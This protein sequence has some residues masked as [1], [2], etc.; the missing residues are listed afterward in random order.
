MTE[1]CPP[2]GTKVEDRHPPPLLDDADLEGNIDFVRHIS[3]TPACRQATPKLV[4]CSAPFPTCADAPDAPRLE[5]DEFQRR[6]TALIKE[7]FLSRDLEG[8]M[9]SIQALGCPSY[10]DELA[11]LLLR[12]ALD[13][14][15]EERQSVV[16]LMD[17]LMNQGHLQKPQMMR[18]FEKLVLAWDD[19][20]LDVPD[21]AGRIVALLSSKV[22]LLDKGLFS[23]LP[24]DLLR[25]LASALPAGQPREVLEQHVEDLAEFKEQAN[26]KLETELFEKKDTNGIAT[27]LRNVGKPCFHHE[28]VMSACMGALCTPRELLKERQGLALRLLEDLSGGDAVLDEVDLHLGFSRLL[29]KIGHLTEGMAAAD[30][31]ELMVGLLRGAVE[32]EVLPAEFLKSARRM[33]FGGPAGVEV[34]RK[35]QRQTPQHSRRVWGTGDARQFRTE[36]REAIMEYFDSNSIQEL[37]RIVQELH[38]SEQEQAKFVR[39]LLVTGMERED[40]ETAL[41]AVQELLGSCWSSVE[42]QDAFQQLRDVAPDLVLDLPRCREQT[43]DLVWAAVGRGLLEQSDLIC[44]AATIV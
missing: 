6:A 7:F 9:G 3:E 35:A 2:Q 18:G 10:H 23:R 39:K 42:V 33:R 31:S 1:V 24:E 12:T 8:M 37:G 13:R 4:G 26:K 17:K 30:V 34:V 21:V 22:G 44:D 28:V 38:L 43:N 32:R 36:V 27:W 11:S 16:E 40:T 15:D 41:D 29:G 19:L 14:G 5:F 25:T 20:Q